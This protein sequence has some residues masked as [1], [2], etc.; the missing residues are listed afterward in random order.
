MFSACL[1]LLSTTFSSISL[2]EIDGRNLY[3]LYSKPNFEG[4]KVCGSQRQVGWVGWKW[5]NQISSI[6]IREGYQLVASR[7]AWQS[8][9]TEVFSGDVANVGEWRRRIW[10]FYLRPLEIE[11]DK[12]CYYSKKNFRGERFCSNNSFR[13]LG[14][15]WNNRISSVSIPAGHEVTLFSFWE[16]YGKSITL[17]NSAPHLGK[18]N[19]VTSSIKVRDIGVSD[20]EDSDGVNDDADLCPSTPLGE[21]VDANGCGETQLDSDD[22]GVNN[23]LDLCPETQGGDSVDDDGCSLVQLD[24]DS[25]GINDAID[26]CPST[27]VGESVNDIGCGDSQLDSDGDGV[28][29]ALDQC[30]GTPSNE[31]ANSQGCSTSQLDTDSDGISDALDQCPATPSAEEVDS[32]GCGDSQ[33]DSDNDG[34]SNA[35][36]QCPNTADGESVNSGGCSPSQLD[37]DNDGVND[38]LD[39]CPLTPF[40]EAVDINGCANSQ[41]DSD[42]DGVSNGGDQCPNT[43]SGEAPNADGC[44]PSQLDTD[45]DGVSDNV[46]QCPGTPNGEAID[47]N[48]CSATQ[49]DTDGDGISDAADQCPGTPSDEVSNSEG[50]SSSQLDTD[51]DG[52][53]DDLDQC[54]T[55]PTDE[56]VDTEGCSTS[57]RD[58]DEDGVSDAEDI[59]PNTSNDETV[60]SE[61]CSENQLDSDEDGISDAIDLCPNTLEGE[62]VDEQG[63]SETQTPIVPD[64]DGDGIQDSFDL[65]PNTETN[66]SV[67]LDGC[68]LNQTDFDSDSVSDDLDQCPGTPFGIVVN[69][70]GCD[71]SQLLTPDMISVFNPTATDVLFEGSVQVFGSVQYDDEVG[72]SV[73]GFA[74]NMQPGNNSA[75][76]DFSANLDLDSGE[77]EITVT[78][79][80][81][82]G[83]TASRTFFVTVLDR[84]SIEIGT[85]SDQGFA[86]FRVE[87]TTSTQ[88]DALLT[89]RS[90][91]IGNDGTF[92]VTNQGSV[93]DPIS[94]DSVL[95]FTLPSAGTFP[96]KVIV[97]DQ[98]GASIEQLL[99]FNVMNRDELAQEYIEMWND[100][101]S[102]IFEGDIKS[103]VNELTTSAGETY[104]PIFQLLQDDFQSIV[105]SYSEMQC[106]TLMI[107]FASCAIVRTNGEGLRTL[108]LIN[109]V[110][111]ANGVRKI[112]GM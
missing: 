2:A 15:Y 29:N 22:D 108:H 11:Q 25:D 56:T 18:F 57:Q 82:F 71:Q 112:S 14:W 80:N 12:V 70:V 37:T 16:F 45:I 36:D 24:S 92:E 23:A 87:I 51:N 79:T 60:N 101:N 53:N 20:D 73:N 32:N 46:D 75:T 33:L 9:E 10:S 98:N 39:I 97:Q 81:R 103:A 47:L 93:N 54:P 99:V 107:D 55:T 3:C 91:D 84:P 67:N 35:L 62:V 59:C 43:P 52:V 77:Q 26:Q 48:G 89:F 28:N 110:R 74:A 69:E 104:L 95:A 106:D 27:P 50:C 100:M 49:L 65:C 38:A 102:F 63:C 5:Y 44:S 94:I 8:G 83:L 41:L 76:K 96:V 105:D 68:A 90:I 109:F 7:Y 1:L 13:Y 17:R 85:P 66:L 78:A 58:S 61:G 19:N 40:G 42:N 6:K 86:P 21:T 4:S 64:N 88:G 34:I 31:I 111:T 72:I 30:P